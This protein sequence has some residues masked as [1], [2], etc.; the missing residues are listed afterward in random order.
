E[1]QA[2][3]GARQTIL[4]H[5]PALAVC[6]YHRQEHLWEIPLYLRDL[7]DG[8]RFFLRRHGDEFGDVVCYALP[9]A[10]AGTRGWGD[11]ETRRRGDTGTRGKVGNQEHV[12]GA[13]RAG[14]GTAV[15]QAHEKLP[16]TRILVHPGFFTFGR[17]G[18]DR[19][20]PFELARW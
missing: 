20:D 10:D 18:H 2:L 13:G 5:H 14:E 4:R 11:A 8:Y 3:A 17:E 12:S 7:W 6:V 16:L 15:G 19:P 1:P 9:V